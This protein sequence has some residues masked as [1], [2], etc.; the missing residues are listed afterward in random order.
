MSNIDLY[1][2]GD[3][4]NVTKTEDYSVSF[5]ETVLANISDFFSNTDEFLL[6]INFFFLAWAIFYTF[7]YLLDFWYYRLSNS[8]ELAN[9]NK[10]EEA[11]SSAKKTWFYYLCWLVLFNLYLLVPETWGLFSV[12]FLVVLLLLALVKF[13]ILDLA[14]ATFFSNIYDWAKE[15][16][17]SQASS[18]VGKIFAIILLAITS[19]IMF[20]A[21]LMISIFWSVLG[22]F[23]VS[24]GKTDEVKK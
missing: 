10:G 3:A 4:A 7:I 15:K 17:S 8:G 12:I 23:G 1:P 13:L 6:K 18:P 19:S 16:S 11:L 24:G 5:F 22:I 14:K 2:I 9:Y 21:D 20:L